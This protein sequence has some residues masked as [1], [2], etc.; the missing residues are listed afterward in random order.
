MKSFLR[1]KYVSLILAIIF[2]P[3]FA[4]SQN[5]QILK[6]MLS[7]RSS[8]PKMYLPTGTIIGQD[9]ELT[10]IA[11]GA[12]SIKVLSSKEEGVSDYEGKK[13]RLGKDFSVLGEKYSDRAD[14]K[15]NLDPDKFTNHISKRVYFE[16]LAYY[17][18]PKTGKSYSKPVAFFGANAGVSATNGVK[19]LE[20][21]KASSSANLAASARA[22]IPGLAQPQSGF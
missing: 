13:L 4:A 9:I 3:A 1:A 7:N 22:L 14:F 11:P 10:I 8:E 18:D 16:A 19:V 17:K 12:E 6:S 5:F 21:P 20:K 15:L 2:S